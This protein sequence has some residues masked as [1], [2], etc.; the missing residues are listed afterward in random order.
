MSYTLI[1][2]TKPEDIN[3]SRSNRSD[4]IP[5]AH[6]NEGSG[7]YMHFIAS[8]TQPLILTK[9]YDTNCTL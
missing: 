3:K 4:Y 8:S 1:M 2:Y 7:Q 5:A 9:W 6:T